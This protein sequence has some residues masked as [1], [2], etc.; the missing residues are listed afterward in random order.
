M[1]GRKYPLEPLVKLRQ[2]QVD[3]ATEKLARAIAER[4]AAEKQRQAAEASRARA[5]EAASEVRQGERDALERG[6]LRAGDLQRAQAWEIGVSEQ[7]K[8]LTQ[9][10]SAATQDEARAHDEEDG[11]R[12]ELATR[13]ADAEVTDK[14]KARFDAKSVQLDLAKEEE[15]A[16]EVGANKKPKPSDIR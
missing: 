2:R 12:I 9:Q 5:D 10:V 8:R 13:E 16:A 6:A 15:A 1:S 3:D 4:E 11:A 7:R 14:D